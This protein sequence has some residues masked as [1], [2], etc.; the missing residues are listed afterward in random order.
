MS[1]RARPSSVHAARLPGARGDAASAAGGPARPSPS[2]RVSP[3]DPPLGVSL[4]ESLSRCPTP[5]DGGGDIPV[6]LS[7]RPAQG[8]LLGSGEAGRRLAAARGRCGP[9]ARLGSARAGRCIPAARSARSGREWGS[10]CRCRRRSARAPRI[11]RRLLLARPEARSHSRIPAGRGHGPPP[12]GAAAVRRPAL[13]R[14]AGGREAAGCRPGCAGGERR[15]STS[16]PVTW[17]CR[18]PPAPGRGGAWMRHGHAGV[19]GA[20]AG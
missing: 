3:C 19:P 9:C 5:T 2:R 4:R 15:S 20:A 17:R 7:S 16:V 10:R 14:G 12:R 1:V 13:T 18:S 6:A 8:G 11:R